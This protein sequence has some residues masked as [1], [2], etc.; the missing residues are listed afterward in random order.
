MAQAI[1]QGRQS[2]FAAA[3]SNCSRHSPPRLARACRQ[4]ALLAATI[5]LPVDI[6]KARSATG[7]TSS[8]SVEISVSVAP[9]YKLLVREMTR[10]GAVQET[11]P[12]ILCLATNSWTPSLPIMLVRLSNSWPDLRRVGPRLNQR[13]DQP[14]IEIKSC[15][16]EPVSAAPLSLEQEGRPT[17]PIVLL[18]PE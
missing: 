3:V 2:R 5:L 13:T 9:Q 6:V 8:G 18:R 10:A 12:N 11:I 15:A 16:L 1:D 14:G 17:N 4:T 7:P